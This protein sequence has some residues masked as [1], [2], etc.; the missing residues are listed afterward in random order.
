MDTSPLTKVKFV[1]EGFNEINL[2]YPYTYMVYNDEFTSC[3]FRI[4]YYLHIVSGENLV[5]PLAYY[6]DHIVCEN[7]QKRM[8]DALG[9]RIKNWIGPNE[10]AKAQAC[11]V[12]RQQEEN[13]Y[14]SDMKKYFD[15]QEHTKPHG[16]D[17]LYETYF[18]MVNENYESTIIVRDPEIDLNTA[19]TLIPDLISITF[20]RR[21]EK[22]VIFANFGSCHDTSILNDIWFITQLKY[23]YKLWL[24]KYNGVDKINLIVKVNNSM[25][26]IE[27][28]CHLDTDESNYACEPDQYWTQIR[29]LNKAATTIQAFFGED[30]I[31]NPK[32]DIRRLNHVLHSNYMIPKKKNFGDYDPLTVPILRDMFK[33]L[34]IGGLVRN[35][36]NSDSTCRFLIKE[37]MDEMVT[38]LKLEMND[39]LYWQG[40]SK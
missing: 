14:P 11:D 7:G 17:Q 21:K 37:L 8:S 39:Y 16:I 13:P 24:G 30:T 4:M 20:S 31:N 2:S 12:E 26:T 19:T 29:T 22:M 10:L 15:V 32:I 40:H 9:P 25:E 3:P 34:I 1:E 23:M 28:P 6:S 27:V 35:D 5:A 33:A 38:P 18:D 36:H